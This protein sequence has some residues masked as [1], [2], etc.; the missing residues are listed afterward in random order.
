MGCLSLFL[1]IVEPVIRAE[2]EERPDLFSGRVLYEAFNSHLS[3]DS[4]SAS[5]LS[6]LSVCSGGNLWG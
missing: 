5:S 4:V 6:F 1:S 3:R 2:L